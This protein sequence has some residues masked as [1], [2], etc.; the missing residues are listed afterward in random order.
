MASS[1]SPLRDTAV[2][3]RA[4][5]LLA[6]GAAATAGLLALSGIAAPAPPMFETAS[7]KGAPHF[8]ATAQ[9][10]VR[11]ASDEWWKTTYGS[12]PAPMTVTDYEA[13]FG[14]SS[15][16]QKSM[17]AGIVS[18]A[19][20]LPPA[21]REVS[22]YSYAAGGMPLPAATVP[23][24]SAPAGGK[25]ARHGKGKGKRVT[26]LPIAQ[27]V[28]LENKPFDVSRIKDRT[29]IQ[30]ACVGDSLT[31]GVGAS[32]V[33][34]M[35]YPAKLQVKLGAEYAVTNLGLHQRSL[36]EGPFESS[37]GT[38]VPFTVS[39]QYKALVGNTWDVVVVMLGTNDADIRPE[40]FDTKQFATDY[41]HLLTKI[42]SLG[43][44]G[45]PPKVFLMSPPPFPRCVTKVNPT[46]GGPKRQPYI[47][48]E[49]FPVMLPDVAS[50]NGVQFIDM[51][52]KLNPNPN[53][54]WTEVFPYD[55]M[56]ETTSPICKSF[57]VGD[58]CHGVHLNDA[59]YDVMAE[60]VAGNVRDLKVRVTD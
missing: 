28:V 49:L 1:S 17:M 15:T 52:H 18:T 9:C 25:S 45:V 39:E 38:N 11:G 34:K 51:Y 48:N 20:Q 46:S 44:G 42:K 59:G 24:V 50:G 3:S 13:V 33:G 60:T 10:L 23:L 12:V 41:T 29:K 27:K 40:K 36:M 43:R 2:G 6:L 57:C 16:W 8:E 58:D 55:C 47:I 32:N 31:Q 26:A 37:W 35:A 30:V 53:S 56:S 22:A 21:V 14:K 54:P 5:R 4:I 7:K 19:A